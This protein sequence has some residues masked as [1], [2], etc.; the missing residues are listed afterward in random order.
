M[1]L[2]KST[3]AKVIAG[4]VGLA[5]AIVFVVTP[6]TTKAQTI[7][8][9]QAQINALLA[10]IA[11]LQGSVGGTSGSMSYTF[12]SD[13]TVGS[14]GSDVVALQTYLEE[15]A[16]L[17][18]PSGVAKGYFGPLT[19]AA[20]K[21]WQASVGLP[22]TGYFGP[23]SR[24]KIN[25]V[26]P[27]VPPATSGC[28]AGAM[29]NSVT[30]APCTTTPAPTAGCPTG[31]LFNSQTGAPCTT[32]PP[33][34][35]TEGSITT[36]LAAT[37]P[38][39]ANVRQ[40]TDVL[41]YGIE[42]EAVGSDMLTDRVD[43]Q[44]S[45]T[46]TGGSASNPGIFINKIA[47]WQGSTML[48]SWPISSTSFSK[49]SADRYHIILSG[50]GVNVPRGTKKDITFSFSVNALNSTDANRAVTVQGYAGNT[51][52]VRAMDTAG[53]ASYADMSGSANTRS[54]TFKPAGSS[55]LTVS[56]N[57]TLTPKAAN[58]KLST[59]NGI[60]KL[61]MQGFSAKSES[62]DSKI[63]KV[64]VAS[65]ATATAGMP[66]TL[67]LCDGADTACA[68]PLGSVTAGNADGVQSLFSSLSLSVPQ[69]T[70]R[71][72]LIAADFPTTGGG[73][74]ASTS[75]MTNSVQWEQPDG[76]TSSTTPSSEIAGNDHYNA[77]EVPIWTLIS[78]PTPVISEPGFATAASSSI[79]ATLTFTVKGEGGALTKPVIGDFGLCFAS[80]TQT[81]YTAGGVNCI[82]AGA[83]GFT[84]VIEGISP[85][86]SEVGDGGMYTVTVKATLSTTG[87]AGANVPPASANYMLVATSTRATVGSNNLRQTW[88]VSDWHTPFAY[89]TRN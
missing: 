28:P 65:N 45:V 44:V 18:M 55:T 35:A 43:L 66:S 26:A 7:A 78:A 60:T 88:N 32:V 20:T 42:V 16:F 8:E 39:N 51:Q 85:S 37:P 40:T 47:A 82:G 80:S 52:N 13:L 81:T 62:G 17:T 64:I 14:T 63:T 48:K 87:A 12:N 10:T 2:T 1:N 9:L 71:N 30:G 68:S 25:A 11:S 5:L 6:V 49:D 21:S 19:Q 36:R 56:L 76:S 83:S 69:D 24:A 50:L 54:H 58:H 70:T 15:R 41:V 29:Y 74:Q 61:I 59:T 57:N 84:S 33:T 86:D 46:P 3:S 34:G 77:A 79:S 72:F 22:S 27:V 89:L 23:L 38:D 75:L 73:Q 53:F 31:A 67:Y 4:L